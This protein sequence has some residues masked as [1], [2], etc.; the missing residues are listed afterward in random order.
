M[1]AF[2]KPFIKWLLKIG[3]ATA[4]TLS[5]PAIG[6]SSNLVVDDFT[7]TSTNSLG[8]ARLYMDDTMAG[9][10]TSM[11]KDI[12]NGVLHVSGEIAPPRG[13][14]GWASSILP[15]ANMG[16]AH[17]ASSY[18]GIK[19]RL[20]IT[21]GTLSLSA[22]SNEVTNFDY[23]AS[24]ILVP[25]DG[26]FHEVTIP[27]EQMKR[28]W[29]EQIQL[30]PKTLNSISIVAFGLQKGTFEFAVEEVSFY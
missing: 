11:S 7:N 9:G 30:N 14:P 4:L 3:A 12:K 17:D 20:M 5:M 29:S 22:N 18:S 8:L 13:Q 26:Q 25:S 23:H 19:I 24:P 2:K 10:K 27:F 16:E 21:S 28:A 15:L 1:N 6:N